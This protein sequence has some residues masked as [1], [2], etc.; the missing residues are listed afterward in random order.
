MYCTSTAGQIYWNQSGGRSPVHEHS[1][2]LSVIMRTILVK[3]PCTAGRIVLGWDG[4]LILQLAVNPRK[5]ADTRAAGEPCFST[6][7][8]ADA[9]ALGF[10]RVWHLPCEAA[11]RCL[12]CSPCSF[13]SVRT[14]EGRRGGICTDEEGGDRNPSCV[15][16]YKPDRHV[17]GADA[18]CEARAPARDADAL[19]MPRALREHPEAPLSFILLVACLFSVF[20]LSAAYAFVAFVFC[21]SRWLSRVSFGLCAATDRV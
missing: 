4:E 2:R 5:S 13:L 15:R 11:S 19:R 20:L 16:A 18:L 9:L 14:R 12:L 3:A 6:Q 1:L 17:L 21:C 7:D 8:D 10:I